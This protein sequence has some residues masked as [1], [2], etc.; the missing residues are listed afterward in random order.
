MDFFV[1][2]SLSL[3]FIEYV[4][5]YLFYV[6][7]DGIGMYRLAE[8][9]ETAF[10]SMR[11]DELRTVDLANVPTDVPPVVRQSLS[12]STRG[13]LPSEAEDPELEH[14]LSLSR[15]EKEKHLAN[16][17]EREMEAGSQISSSSFRRHARESSLRSSASSGSLSSKSM[18]SVFFLLVLY[19]LL[20]I[21]FPIFSSQFFFCHLFKIPRF[22]PRIALKHIPL[23][24]Y[25]D[26][27][28]LWVIV[29]L[30]KEE[31]SEELAARLQV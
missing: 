23:F 28:I 1:L 7:T 15:E 31:A 8:I 16:L 18:L 26:I 9:E 6:R 30:S 11:I 21:L 19:L 13:K 17:R 22:Y 14:F 5:C 29:A 4:C 20:M 10:G 2:Q 3:F 24:V 12:S 27:S 25:L